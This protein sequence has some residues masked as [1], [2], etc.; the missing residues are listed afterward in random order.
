MGMGI[1]ICT[2]FHVPYFTIDFEIFMMVTAEIAF[3]WVV[4]PYVLCMD[5]NILEEHLKDKSEYGEVA[6]R[7]YRQHARKVMT[8]IRRRGRE[9]R[10]QSRPI[11]TVNRKIIKKMALFKAPM[12]IVT[13]GA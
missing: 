10:S 4:R 3:F 6:A 13:E 7:L 1:H 8:Q 5:T 9:A 11:R 12:L 2:E